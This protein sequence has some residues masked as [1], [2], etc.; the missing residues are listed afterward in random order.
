MVSMLIYSNVK[1]E[2]VELHI[3]SKD[4]IA[5][6]S[7]DYWEIFPLYEF[8]KI[9]GY[10]SE[11]PLLN[12]MIYDVDND[13]AFDYL[14]DIRK[15]YRQSSIM[16]LADTSISPMKYLRPDIRADSLLLK[17]W[18]KQQA[19]S[20]LKDFLK[21]YLKLLMEDDETI[22]NSYV[23]E[24]KDGMTHIPYEQIYFFEAR[25]KKIYVCIGKEAYGFYGTIDK[26]A[27]ELP[28]NFVRCHRGFIVNKNRID[29]VVISQNIIYLDDGFDVPL[30]RSYKPLFKGMR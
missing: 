12:L 7:E 28:S 24:T 8:E 29:R 17:P 10:I 22:E 14:V 15:K 25:E 2:V 1:Q 18:T 26:L 16:L 30:S 19:R 3:I 20:V 11:N 4:V 27:D 5:G 23:V 9:Q 6:V 21:G 13:E